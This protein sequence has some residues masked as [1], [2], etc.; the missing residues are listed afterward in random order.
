MFAHDCMK[1]G[2]LKKSKRVIVL[3]I[4]NR[5]TG[6]VW[7]PK[8]AYGSAQ[9]TVASHITLGEACGVLGGSRRVATKPSPTSS[10][11]IESGS[12][13]QRAERAINNSSSFLFGTYSCQ[14]WTNDEAEGAGWMLYPIKCTAGPDEARISKG[15]DV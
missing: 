5:L 11:L 7:P 9:R 3:L 1:V 12:N 8:A 13:D 6:K 10:R 14:P 2:T 4:Q 15:V